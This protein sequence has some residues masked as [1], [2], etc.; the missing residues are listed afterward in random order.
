MARAQPWPG[1]ACSGLLGPSGLLTRLACPPDVRGCRRGA[2]ARG[3]VSSPTNKAAGVETGGLSGVDPWK[4]RSDRVGTFTAIRLGRDDRETQLLGEC[5]GY[6]SA[7][8][9]CLPAKGIH[10]LFQ[11]GS[12]GPLH[13]GDRLV[14]FAALVRNLDLQFA[15]GRFLRPGGLLSRLGCAW[16][17]VGH[18]RA[19]A[20]DDVGF[21]RRRCAVL[22]SLG[23]GANVGL[24]GC[25]FAGRLRRRRCDGGR[26]LRPAMRCIRFDRGSVGWGAGSLATGTPRF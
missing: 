8:G 7:N 9:M 10:E 2:R 20:G 3:S 26:G 17:N 5:A 1:G 15:N 14:G 24:V 25:W 22:L 18:L 6:K 11:R 23:F 13:H 19:S 21:R 4:L 16:R 12:A